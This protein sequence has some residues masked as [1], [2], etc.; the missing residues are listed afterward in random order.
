M[1]SASMR[2]SESR[3]RLIGRLA[4]RSLHVELL[5]YPKPGLVSPVDS[6]SHDDMN[7]GT[8]MRSLFSLRTYFQK[9]AVAGAA[10]VAF[11]QLVDLGSTA[12]Q[13]MLTATG[14]VNAHRGAIFCLGL[15]CAATGRASAYGA[16]AGHAT[17]P[18]EP[19]GKST[20]DRIVPA[21]VTPACIR[22]AL[23]TTWGDAL[24]LHC[25]QRRQQA[26]GT[27]AMLAYGV[28]GARAEA[29]AGLPSVFEIALPAIQDALDAGRDHRQARIDA[30][31]A[32]MAHTD[33]TNVYHR[34]GAAGARLVRDM[35]RAFIA[36]GGTG[37]PDWHACALGAHRLLVSHRLSP[38]GAAD[39]LAAAV[40]VRMLTVPDVLEIEVQATSD[41]HR[42]S[43]AHC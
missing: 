35:G 43:L 42:N 7:A 31:F 3:L 30:F 33:D 38:G 18:H 41:D 36:R 34:G 40:L 1:T 24:Q 27:G 9:I 32:L 29:A 5:L 26:H 13:R 6:G 22:A 10:G 2:G 4:V 17:L 23:V 20:P 37:A 15:I 28:G 14:G 39:L 21:A 8:F 25:R 12:E 16:R 11:D 19:A